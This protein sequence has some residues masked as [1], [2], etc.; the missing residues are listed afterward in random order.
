MREKTLIIRQFSSG[1]DADNPLE[2]DHFFDVVDIKDLHN[3]KQYLREIGSNFIPFD[4]F[5]ANRA[6][7]FLPNP[8]YNLQIYLDYSLKVTDWVKLQE[9][10]QKL[11]NIDFGLTLCRHPH[12]D[13][14]QAE[15]KA[16]FYSGKISRKEFNSLWQD[17]T[18]KNEN[19]F[20]TQNGFNCSK[21]SIKHFNWA[22]RLVKFISHHDIKRDQLTV[23]LF[24]NDN[25]SKKINYMDWPDFIEVGK[26]RTS[27]PKKIIK[28]IKYVVR[29]NVE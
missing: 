17:I 6:V 3:A 7:K 2:S 28:K 16:C 10:T 8:N 26:H 18:F 4:N 1:Y 19:L 21:Y 29:K 5:T 22:E 9:L 23:P 27:L 15:I 14:F 25:P 11:W 20:L 24:V 12:R 13:N